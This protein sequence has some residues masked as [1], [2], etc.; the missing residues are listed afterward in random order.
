MNLFNF[1]PTDPAFR[2]RWIGYNRSEVDDFVNR[3]NTEL[4]SLK[5]RLARAEEATPSGQC[6]VDLDV[7]AG[8]ARAMLVSARREAEATLAQ[9]RAVCATCSARG[10]SEGPD[11]SGGR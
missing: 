1:R 6:V 8:Q 2:R 9:G 7:A 10:G 3:T 4:D 5:E 11:C